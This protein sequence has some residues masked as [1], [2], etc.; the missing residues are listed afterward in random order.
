MGK[1]QAGVVTD[2]GDKK[3]RKH[4]RDVAT[5]RKKRREENGTIA[6]ASTSGD[7]GDAS[8]DLSHA[9]PAPAPPPYASRS[10]PLSRLRTWAAPAGPMGTAVAIVGCMDAT[11]IGGASSTPP[12]RSGSSGGVRTRVVH[13]HTHNTTQHTHF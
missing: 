13:H 2:V 12:P 4:V 9:A 11:I 10:Y 8:S 1:R 3:K 6:R 5:K 7:A